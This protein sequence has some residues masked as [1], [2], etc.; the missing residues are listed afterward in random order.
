MVNQSRKYH[1]QASAP[2][3]SCNK[4]SGYERKSFT[5]VTLSFGLL[6]TDDGRSRRESTMMDVIDEFW[7]HCSSTSRPMKPVEPAKMTFIL[8][9]LMLELQS[10]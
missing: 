6:A 10:L 3:M 8:L 2:L 9:D 7:R 5:I 1:M 4:D